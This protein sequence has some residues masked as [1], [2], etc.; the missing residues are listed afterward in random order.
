[1]L[2]ITFFLPLL[3]LPKIMFAVLMT[4]VFCYHVVQIYRYTPF[5]NKTVEN[6]NSNA[7]SLHIIS[8]NVLESNKQYGKFINLI[9][10]HKPDLFLV[11]E[12]NDVWDKQ[13]EKLEVLYPYQIKSVQNNLYGISLYSSQPF[14]DGKVQF[15]VKSDIPSIKA[16]IKFKNNTIVLYGIHPEPPIYGEALTSKPRDYEFDKIAELVKRDEKPSIVIGDMNDV[17]WS[18]NSK[19]FVRESGLNDPSIGRLFVNSFHTKYFFTR[20]PIDQFFVSKHFRVCEYKRLQHIGSD[21]FPI[22]VKISIKS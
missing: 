18:K 4:A 13:L 12:V 7:D 10:Y 5:I 1:M 22:Q 2:I 16:S 6:S 14:E 3:I 8:F 20:L 15:L 11:M 21:H 9:K 17:P 19:K